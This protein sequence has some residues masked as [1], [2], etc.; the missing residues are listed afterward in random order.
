[1]DHWRNAAN[2]RWAALINQETEGMNSRRKID[3]RRF[4]GG[5]KT[6]MKTALRSL[7]HKAREMFR[8]R[9]QMHD[10]MLVLN[11]SIFNFA[12]GWNRTFN[13]IGIRENV[14]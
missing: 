12:G 1:M 9:R 14:A 3:G 4:V 7:T 5:R 13:E 11:M 10:P 8:R 6:T 2:R